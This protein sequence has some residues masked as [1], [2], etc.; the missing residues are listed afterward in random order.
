MQ[1]LDQ[2][3]YNSSG[4]IPKGD[5]QNLRRVTEVLTE[6]AIVLVFGKND[7]FSLTGIDPNGGV[8]CPLEAQVADMDRLGKEV[9]QNVDEAMREVLVDEQFHSVGW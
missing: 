5:P 9:P 6:P 7:E 8:G 4:A 2:I 3:P 1:S